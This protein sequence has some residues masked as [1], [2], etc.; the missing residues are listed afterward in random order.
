MTYLYWDGP[1]HRCLSAEIYRHG[2]SRHKILCRNQRYV[3]L[4]ARRSLK[5]DFT[6]HAISTARL[7]DVNCKFNAMTLRCGIL[8]S[9]QISSG[10]ILYGNS[11]E[12]QP[13]QLNFDAL[14]G[15][16]RYIQVSIYLVNSGAHLQTNANGRLKACNMGNAPSAGYLSTKFTV[17]IASFLT[18]M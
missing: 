9:E 4:T 3:S 7:P 6:S 13:V 10:I 8:S 15:T 17:F 11:D 12:R 14:F 18:C 5:L 2:T 16:C 1:L